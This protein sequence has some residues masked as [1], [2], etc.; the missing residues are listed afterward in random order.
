MET[1]YRT[2]PI[3]LALLDRDLRFL[4]INDKLAEIDGTSIDA[5]IGRTLR[6][7]VPSVADTIE[8]LYRQVIET[9]QSVLQMEIYGTTAA[10]PGIARDW[11]VDYYP[12][13]EPDGSVQGVA[14]IVSEITERKRAEDALGLSEQRFRDF[15]DVR[16]GL[17][18]E[19]D[20]EHRFTW[21]SPNVSDLIGVPPEWHYGKTRREIM[22]PGVDP[23]LIEAHWQVL[24]AHLPFRD[25][26][27][28]RRGP[29]GDVWLS[30]EW[31]PG[32][33]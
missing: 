29:D 12:M 6:E 28:L 32:L 33:R 22:A 27:Y 2:A 8:P 4:R 19:S 15:R 20:A 21:L 24:E 31:R 7:V 16:L 30:T 23:E 14:A 1:L 25:L 17:A 18:R 10:Q 13:K 9:G 3:G 26:E 11:L 5:H